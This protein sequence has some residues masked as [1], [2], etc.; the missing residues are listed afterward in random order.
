MPERK[1]FRYALTDS[2]SGIPTRDEFD[3][4]AFDAALAY[5]AAS[6]ALDDRM[7]WP[8]KLFCAL[9][10]WLWHL[11]A[12]AGD[13]DP[14]PLFAAVMER[15][16]TLL[17]AARDSRIL[18]QSFPIADCGIPVNGAAFEDRVSSTFS[19]IW[20]NLSDDVYFDQSYAFTR[21]RFEKSGFNAEQVFGDKVV[22]DAGCGSGKFSAALARL[23]A[24]KVIGLDLGEKGLA[25]AR[26]QAAK[27][28]YGNRLEF[29]HGSLLNIPLAD[30]SVDAV[31]S[32]GVIHHTLGYERCLAEFARVI[33]PGGTLYLYVNGRFGLFELLADTVRIAIQDVPRALYMHY[34]MSLGVNTG[35][36][37]WIL[38]YAYPPYEWK[39]HAEVTSLMRKHGFA[40]IR[41]LTRGVATDQIEQVT[42]NLPYAKAKYGEAQLKYLATRSRPATEA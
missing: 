29:R 24:A 14:V 20:V 27:V 28:S 4:R 19:D 2:L 26:T 41:Q 40:D 38:D 18:T 6:Q 11:D 1:S 23:G 16:T 9:E 21:E 31:W 39:S 34:L 33:K 25:F 10:L 36:L 7:Y 13:D 8:V 30:S 35:R 22:L 12:F 32:N 15:A 37:Y 5:V 42:L 17:R 3:V